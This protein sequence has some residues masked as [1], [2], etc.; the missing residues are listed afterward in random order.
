MQVTGPA[1]S[2]SSDNTGPWGQREA[3]RP[4]RDAGRLPPPHKEGWHLAHV[5]QGLLG[6][7]SPIPILCLPSPTFQL[8]T[9]SP[10]CWEREGGRAG[11]GGPRSRGRRGQDDVI[12]PA[13]SS[14]GPHL[15]TAGWGGHLAPGVRVQVQ[16]GQPRAAP[17]RAR[18]DQAMGGTLGSSD[19]HWIYLCMNSV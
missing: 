6:F 2:L 18:L 16:G 5:R 15:A 14:A 7:T 13:A 11:E 9:A 1:Q 12:G 19:S 17:S 4:C 3:H 8:C 10:S